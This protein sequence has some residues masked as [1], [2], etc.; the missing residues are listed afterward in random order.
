MAEVSA[1]PPNLETQVANL[2]RKYIEEYLR[3]APTGMTFAWPQTEER[4]RRFIDSRFEALLREMNARFEA[5]AQERQMILREM[6]K[7]FEAVQTQI[8]RLYWTITAWLT[9][10]SLFSGWMAW[11]LYQSR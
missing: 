6:D 9:I 10:L 4:L 11:L 5:A 3:T 1:L 2:V 8:R 7:R